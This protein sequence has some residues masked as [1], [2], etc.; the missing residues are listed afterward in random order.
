MSKIYSENLGYRLVYIPVKVAFKQFF[1]QIEV[2]GVD[3]IP[4]HEPVIFAPNH[5]TGLMD[6]LA[7]LF[8]RD[9]SPVVFM[10]RADM[11]KSKVLATVLRFLKIMPVFRIRD[12]FE[13][14]GKNEARFNEAK[15]VLLVSKN[16]CLMPE[17][18]HGDRHSLRPLVKGL[19]RIAFLAEEALTKD[20]HVRIVPVGIDHS[21]FQ[22][23]GSDLVVTYGQPLKVEDYMTL[24]QDN[25]ATGLNAIKTDLADN[26]SPL[27]HDIR[28]D[29]NYDLV[30]WL[31]C[32]AT[33]A[34]LSVQTG[35]AQRRGTAQRSGFIARTAAGHRFDARRALSLLLDELV[36]AD[37]PL[38]KEWEALLPRIKALPGYPVEV[39]AWLEHKPSFFKALINTVLT[40]LFL[41]GLLLNA[42]G[43]LLS[44]L[45]IR[46]VK[47][48]QMHNTIA[49][50]L[51]FFFNAI[52]YTVTAI[53]LGL[54]FS[55]TWALTIGLVGLIGA[56][57]LLAERWRQHLRA[58][59]LRLRFQ[60]RSR[61]QA[62]ENAKT[63]YFWL[64]QS[65]LKWLNSR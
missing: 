43:W 27:M 58:P 29:A 10:A 15:D 18:N 37:N 61:R 46:G 3:N 34:W 36:K 65:V 33:P 28:S 53:V 5:Q 35:T 13:N 52:L 32:L 57:G 54:V 42:P 44:R 17:G 9:N 2:R 60:S 12:G 48:K 40:P 59:L 1:R 47:D 55:Y 8:T 31:S 23:A 26:L 6:P 45:I 14:L 25:P 50:L 20:Q 11:F 24:Y 41:P 7:V 49:F 30:Y 4:L 38:L 56:Y 64:K 63:D 22:H 16:L 21:H 62:V 39:T 19:F 51:G